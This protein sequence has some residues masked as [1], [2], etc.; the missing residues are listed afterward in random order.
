[1]DTAQK[2]LVTAAAREAKPE[3]EGEGAD[4]RRSHREPVVTLGM[5][6]SL[7]E[8]ERFERPRQVLITNVSLHGVGFR[9]PERL[10]RD[11]LYAI[12]IGMGP[13]HLSSRLRL[14]R[15]RSLPDGTYDIGAEF[16]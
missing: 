10:D 4:R 13:L 12:E 7:D 5:V 3:P 6:R 15:V 2:K 14:V 9:S 1:M 11:L 8:A 16:C